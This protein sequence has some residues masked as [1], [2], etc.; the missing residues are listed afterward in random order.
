MTAWVYR[1]PQYQQR[2]RPLA[3]AALFFQ[4]SGDISAVGTIAIGTAAG[5]TSLNAIAATGNIDIAATA[6]RSSLNAINAVGSIVI[7]VTPAVDAIVFRDAVATGAITIGGTG[8]LNAF[9]FGDLVGTLSIQVG[10]NA[11]ISSIIDQPVLPVLRPQFRSVD[12]KTL[13]DNFNRGLPEVPAYDW[14]NRRKFYNE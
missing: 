6:V 14:P 10:T 4:Q 11:V 9:S 7:G 8:N 5:A 13:A 2:L 12:G 1:R 3:L